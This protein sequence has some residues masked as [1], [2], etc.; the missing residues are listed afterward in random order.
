MLPS[1]CDFFVAMAP[2]AGLKISDLPI[3]NCWRRASIGR[4]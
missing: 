1:F 2:A 3:G 4:L